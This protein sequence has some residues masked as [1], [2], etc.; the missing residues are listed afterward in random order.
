MK[1][2]YRFTGVLI[3][4][5]LWLLLLFVWDGWLKGLAWAIALI[6]VGVFAIEL[7]NKGSKKTNQ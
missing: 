5:G 7:I 4:V 3:L 1:L 6:V 2:L